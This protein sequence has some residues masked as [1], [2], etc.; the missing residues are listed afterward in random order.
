MTVNAGQTG[1]MEHTDSGVLQAINELHGYIK[2][3]QATYE[4]I[5]V[6]QNYTRVQT[7][8][9]SSEETCCE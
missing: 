3:L 5:H 4:Q 1:K 9:Y 8:Y 6:I 2:I 7:Q